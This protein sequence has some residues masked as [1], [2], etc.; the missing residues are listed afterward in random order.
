M[1]FHARSIGGKCVSHLRT[2]LL[3]DLKLLRPA[4]DRFGRLI[5]LENLAYPKIC[6]A[7]QTVV[8]SV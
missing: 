5:T 4:L 3:F 8:F 6:V 1:I 7:H 2:D